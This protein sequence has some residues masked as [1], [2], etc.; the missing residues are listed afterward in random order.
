VKG[1]IEN[2]A[3]NICNSS[4]YEEK[5]YP[6]S[7]GELVRCKKCDLY[8]ASPRRTDFISQIINN[9]TEEGLYVGKSLNYIGRIREFMD[10]LGVIETLKDPPGRILDV[11]CYEGFFLNE[12]RRRGWEPYGV[13]PHRGGTNHAKNGL[14]LDVRQCVLEKAFFDDEYFDVVTFLSTLEHVPDPSA[15][16]REAFRI[17]K[18]DGLLVI[19]V[20]YIPFYLTFIK[21]KW[22]MFIGDHYWFFTDAS[23]NRMLGKH[24]FEVIRSGYVK[25]SVDLETISARL[26]SEWQP[27][28]L[29]RIGGLLSKMV[30]VTGAGRLRFILNLLDCKVYFAR[31]ADN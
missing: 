3:C 11:G 17:M 12:A 28:S 24:G 19:A 6:I 26:A 14:G 16:L 5:Y 29:G 27:M 21:S 1:N 8:Y 2:V 31:K 10:Y 22:R 9:E 30:E 4:D 20:P 18:G 7:S 25:K 23:I 15:V 13:E